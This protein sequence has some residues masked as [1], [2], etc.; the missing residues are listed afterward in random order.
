VKP[1]DLICCYL[2]DRASWSCPALHRGSTERVPP[3][4]LAPDRLRFSAA[5]NTVTSANR[6]GDQPS[7]PRSANA[8][9]NSASA[10]NSP[11]SSRTAI[12][13]GGRRPPYMARTARVISSAGSG[14]GRGCNDIAPP[15][16]W[17]GTRKKADRDTIIPKP[18]TRSTRATTTADLGRAP[19][20]QQAPQSGQLPLLSS[21]SGRRR[22]RT[23][24][25]GRQDGSRP[26]RRKVDFDLARRNRSASS[27]ATNPSTA[28]DVPMRTYRTAVEDLSLQC[29]QRNP[30]TAAKSP[31]IDL[32]TARRAVFLV[33]GGA[34]MRPAG[35]GGGEATPDRPAIYHRWAFDGC[36]TGC[37]LHRCDPG[38]GAQLI[39]LGCDCY[40]GWIGDRS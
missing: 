25:G 7:G 39:P 11:N 33:F 36:I 30:S 12:G 21:R 3:R 17:P 14:H 15:I 23:R 6:P 10:N 9:A 28:A 20:D 35:S 38:V 19:N 26:R 29:P 5:W 4:D 37:S 1:G 32:S 24:G 8:A 40:A 2:C 18:R 27:A 16:L 31:R 13:S 34:V 22:Y